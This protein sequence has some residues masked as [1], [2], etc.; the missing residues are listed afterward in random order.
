MN[1]DECPDCGETDCA[2]KWYADRE[3]EFSGK[4]RDDLQDDFDDMDPVLK[5]EVINIYFEQ[6]EQI[7]SLLQSGTVLANARLELLSEIQQLKE[8]PTTWLCENCE[9]KKADIRNLKDL[10]QYWLGYIDSD[11]EIEPPITETRE[12]LAATPQKES[13]TNEPRKSMWLYRLQN[14]PQG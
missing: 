14:Y 11:E 7:E 2:W 12:A 10:L 1:I 4:L 5:A 3:K 8:K 9:S 6:A 13:E